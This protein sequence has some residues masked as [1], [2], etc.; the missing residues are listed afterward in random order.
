MKTGGGG[1]G[2]LVTLGGADQGNIGLDML[3]KIEGNFPIHFICSANAQG[4]RDAQQFADNSDG[5]VSV[6]P[7]GDID[8]LMLNA[9]AAFCAG[10]VTAL[11]LASL[12][13]P[14]VIMTTADNQQIGA[15]AL[16]EAGAAI[17]ADS[18]EEAAK[19]AS[20]LMANTKRR[21]SMAGAG[22]GLIDGRGAERV[23]KALRSL[24]TSDERRA[25]YIDRADLGTVPESMGEFEEFYDSRRSKIRNRLE[26]TLGTEVP[27]S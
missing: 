21:K 25:D 26:S 14:S 12:G 17:R 6:R 11:E 9:D 24:S 19:V 27:T 4:M 13:V 2:L 7:P 8:R 15:S 23:T 5:R 10:G 3:R 1:G 20:S 22:R 18:V 16:T